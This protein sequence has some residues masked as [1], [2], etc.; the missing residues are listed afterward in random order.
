M[1]GVE[2]GRLRRDGEMKTILETFPPQGSPLWS[3]R[4]WKIAFEERS[5][6]VCVWGAFIYVATTKHSLPDTSQMLPH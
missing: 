5:D 2:Q 4:G 6:G 1:P 3:P